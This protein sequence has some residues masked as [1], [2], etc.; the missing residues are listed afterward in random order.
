MKSV[1]VVDD[2]P[3]WRDALTQLIQASGEFRV[4]FQAGSCAEARVVLA[5][6]SFDLATVDLS[7]PD[8]NGL[9]LLSDIKTTQED[10][11]A[12]VI[13][14]EGSVSAAV[15]AL[16][17]GALGFLSKTISSVSLTR[18]LHQV[19]SGGL[20][21]DGDM[22]VDVLNRRRK[23]GSAD[24]LSDREIE[25]LELMC[26]G[27]TSTVDLMEQMHLSERSVKNA[28]SS[29]YVKLAVLDRAGAVA[30]AFRDGLVDSANLTYRRT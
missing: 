12:V 9:S 2:H 19:M 28:L 8:G 14:A 5:R 27:V 11:A 13:T 26:R 29:L 20:A 15:R 21:L 23:Q 25:V 6:N 4:M 24:S 30:A 18:N 3:V 16:D 7:L 10:C 22:A 17:A 1:L